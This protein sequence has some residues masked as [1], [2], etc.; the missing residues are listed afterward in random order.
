[1]T[2]EETYT[3]LVNQQKIKGEEDIRI[4]SL[5]MEKDMDFMYAENMIKE[6]MLGLQWMDKLD[7][8]LLLSTEFKIPLL[9]VDL[10][11]QFFRL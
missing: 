1:M 6:M 8:G 5:F 11:Y 2:Q 4:I 10:I 3:F 7:N 9:F